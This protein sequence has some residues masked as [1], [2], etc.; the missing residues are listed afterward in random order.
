MTVPNLPLSGMLA[1]KYWWGEW[2]EGLNREGKSALT[3]Q[4]NL[5]SIELTSIEV[6]FPSD[7][8]LL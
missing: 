3:K 8:E 6:G 5:T 2:S 1:S 7:L 4:L